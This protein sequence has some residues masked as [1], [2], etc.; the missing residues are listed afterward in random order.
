MCLYDEGR[1]GFLLLNS[2]LTVEETETKGR[3]FQTLNGNNW[4][5]KVPL[6]SQYC[7]SSSV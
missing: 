1:H 6:P 7:L 2:I 3:K 5:I 4:L